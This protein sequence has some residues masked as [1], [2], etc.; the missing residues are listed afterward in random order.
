MCW[1]CGQP[2]NKK[3]L[4]AIMDAKTVILQAIAD[5]KAQVQAGIEEAKAQIQAL[6]DQLAAGSVIT[7][8]DL[9]VILTSVQ[10]IYTPEA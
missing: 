1:L 6:K 7:P 4:E 9:D 8:A 5:E 10:N 3:I 2:N